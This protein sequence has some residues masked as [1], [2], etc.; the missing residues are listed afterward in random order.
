MG[1][2]AAKVVRR[3]TRARDEDRTVR[4]QFLGRWRP[5]WGYVL[6]L[7]DSWVVVHALTDGYYLDEVALHRLEDVERV[8]KDPVPDFTRRVVGGLAVP[9]ATFDADPGA[10]LSTLLRSVADRGQLV[11][12]H[13]RV[14][15]DHLHVEVGTILGVRKKHLVLHAMQGDG[16]WAA[17]P[18]RR[19]LGRIERASVGG[20]YL[21]ALERFGDPAPVRDTDA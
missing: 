1:H 16:T 18:G 2:S 14:A 8:D 7:T 6:A 4:L 21:A 19:G 12:L 20:R 17:A 9:V 13:Q 5:T 15:P 11:M 10:T 3:L